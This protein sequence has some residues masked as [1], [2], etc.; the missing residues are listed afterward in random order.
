MTQVS[1][2]DVIALLKEDWVPSQKK[3]QLRNM[4]LDSIDMA[5][6]MTKTMKAHM[7]DK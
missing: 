6:E 4:I 1:M 3:E 5:E 2:Q 7:G